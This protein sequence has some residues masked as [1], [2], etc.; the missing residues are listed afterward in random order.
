MSEDT[1]EGLR[2]MDRTQ[3]SVLQEKEI[4]D[5]SLRGHNHTTQG[6]SFKV[7]QTGRPLET[8][9]IVSYYL[10][11]TRA[12]TE[13]LRSAHHVTH[14]TNENIKQKE[15]SPSLHV[16]MLAAFSLKFYQIIFFLLVCV[17]LYMRKLTQ[18]VCT[19]YFADHQTQFFSNTVMVVMVEITE[20]DSSGKIPPFRY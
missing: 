14:K 4:K 15:K 6:R 8:F 12:C 9:V 17:Y 3:R 11:F 20:R 7:T 13:I 1:E 10:G 16:S 2:V 5:R 18:Y 19:F